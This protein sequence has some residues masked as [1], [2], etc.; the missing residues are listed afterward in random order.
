MSYTYSSLDKRSSGGGEDADA[1]RK[2]FGD[3]E[4]GGHA[5]AP[6]V[7]NNGTHDDGGDSDPMVGKERGVILL[8]SRHHIA[9]PIS[10][11]CIGFL[12]R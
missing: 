11:F 3:S 7:D 8:T 6:L 2:G 12:G 9:I 1:K 4:T 5:Y 10:Y